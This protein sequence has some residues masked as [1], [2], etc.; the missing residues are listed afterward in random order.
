MPM[1]KKKF[2]AAI[3]IFALLFSLVGMQSLS[4]LPSYQADTSWIIVAKQLVQNYQPYANTS[5]PEVTLSY[6]NMYMAENGT[7]QLIYYGNGDTLSIYLGEL[8]R[9]GTI[10]KGS[11]S[12]D[13]LDKVLANGTAIILTYRVSILATQYPEAK[14]YQGC[15][16][17]EDKLNE[18]LQG[19]IIAREMNTSDLVL[20]GVPIPSPTL[21]PSPSVAEVSTIKVLSPLNDSFFNVS[22]GGVSFPLTYETNSNL[23]WVG[24]SF[25]GGSNWTLPGNGSHVPP[26]SSSNGYHTLTVYANDTSGNW[27]TPQTVTYL[28]NVHPDYTPTTSPSPSVAEFPNWIILPLMAVAATMIVYLRRRRKL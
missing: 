20:L 4:A 6:C 18:G 23:S 1:N 27:A 15:F 11:T 16:I 7:K 10:Y 3:A 21:E 9:N 12:E 17:L 2:V 22:L 19:T 26:V 5:N 24:F 13:Y 8:L 28:V 25:D 14:Y